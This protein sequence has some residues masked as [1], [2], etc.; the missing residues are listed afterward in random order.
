MGVLIL[1][2]VGSLKGIVSGYLWLSLARCSNDPEPMGNRHAATVTR[3]IFDKG[4]GGAQ[5]SIS[6][7]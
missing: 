2:S 3:Q 7:T 1:K 5:S 4:H 6:L